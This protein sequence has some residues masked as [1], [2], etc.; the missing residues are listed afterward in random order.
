MNSEALSGGL[1]VGGNS[2]NRFDFL[3][4]YNLKQHRSWIDETKLDNL[5]ETFA[6]LFLLAATAGF[7]LF[8]LHYLIFE[9]PY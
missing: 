1:G 5:K 8:V 9:A 3:P 7:C 6:S 4:S 2:K